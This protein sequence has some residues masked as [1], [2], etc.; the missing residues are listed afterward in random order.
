MSRTV[1]VA[2]VGP[3][4]GS[5]IAR[6]AAREGCDVTLLARSEA[7]IT[8]L[9]ST[10]DAETDGRALAVPTD[11]TDAADVA[12][13]FRTTREAFGP[14]DA[15]VYNPGG[16]PD[17]SGPIA[18]TDLDDLRRAWELKV[19]GAHRCVRAVLD[20]M[21]D[22]GALLFT[23][24]AQSKHASAE[25]SARASARHALRGLAQSYARELG[26]EGVHVAHLVVD[27]WVD[28]P[29]LRERFPDH[30]PWMDPDEVADTCW[31]LLDQPASARTFELDLRAAGDDVSF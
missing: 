3:G 26:P 30:E 23:N 11:L 22:G 15:L 16:A 8:D 19:A 13:A 18:D 6:R 9:A 4:V 24:S 12:D 29:A 21:G 28:K 5:S 1:V 27:G 25:S 10:L 14:V 17:V 7:R 20:D 2:G 31:H